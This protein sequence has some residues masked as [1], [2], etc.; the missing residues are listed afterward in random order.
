LENH[1][2]FEFGRFLL[3]SALASH[4]L[5]DCANFMATLEENEKYSAN[6]FSAIQA[7]SQS[8]FINEQLHL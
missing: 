5:E 6:I 8:T 4:W 7:S 2:G 1:A 3:A